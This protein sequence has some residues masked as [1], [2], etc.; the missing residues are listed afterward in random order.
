MRATDPII[1]RTTD[2][3]EYRL[4]LT[5]A[6]LRRV[7]QRFNARTTAELMQA[8]E[9]DAIGAILYE[10]LPPNDR[11]VMTEEQLYERLPADLQELSVV[12]VRL[13]GGEPGTARPQVVQQPVESSTG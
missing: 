2:G 3:A 6:G 5:L 4:V 9:L 13:L 1:I 12:A 11:A 7:M 8:A 10:A